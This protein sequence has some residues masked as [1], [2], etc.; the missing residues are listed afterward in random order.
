MPS[1]NV[2]FRHLFVVPNPLGVDRVVVFA[3]RQIERAVNAGAVHVDLHLGVMFRLGFLDALIPHVVER[4]QRMRLEF[5][6]VP[7]VRRFRNPALDHGIQTARNVASKINI[8]LLFSVLN[9]NSN[10]SQVFQDIGFFLMATPEQAQDAAR[11]C[12]L[13]RPAER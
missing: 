9:F 5:S 8:G 10:R 4:F 13:H 7:L 11:K 3:D 12:G 1:L 6:N 2:F